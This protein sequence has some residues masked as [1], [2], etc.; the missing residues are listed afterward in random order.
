[1]KQILRFFIMLSAP[2]LFAK[3]PCVNGMAG[4]FPCNGLTLQGHISITNLGG[5]AYSG[6]NPKEA[7]D[8]WGWTDPL[9]NKE[10]ALVT[11]ND[12]IS[13]V[14]IST[15]TKPLL[16]MDYIQVCPHPII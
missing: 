1:M 8:S 9:D 6:N 10:Y 7:Q 2:L 15:P 14:D 12:G 11:L 4:S 5:K 13:F 3:T 16:Q